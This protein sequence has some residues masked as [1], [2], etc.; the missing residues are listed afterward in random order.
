MYNGSRWLGNFSQLRVWTGKAKIKSIFQ[1]QNKK[2]VLCKQPLYSLVEIKVIASPCLVLQLLLWGRHFFRY[3]C[4]CLCGFNIFFPARMGFNICVASPAVSE[5]EKSISGDP[6]TRVE[7]LVGPGPS[8]RIWCHC[9]CLYILVACFLYPRSV[10]WTSTRGKHS[11][12]IAKLYWN[13]SNQRKKDWNSFP[14]SWV[15][16]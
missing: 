10:N 13:K 16:E 4:D 3:F 1:Q 7:L 11:V 15:H 2:T 8:Q 12:R 14:F 5:D 6:V 9:A